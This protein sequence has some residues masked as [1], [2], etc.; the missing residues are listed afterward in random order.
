MMFALLHLPLCEERTG[1]S[2]ITESFIYGVSSPLS[3]LSWICLQISSCF[4]FQ[5]SI[6]SGCESSML[7]FASGQDEFG[8]AEH[9]CTILSV[10]LLPVTTRQSLY[11]GDDVGLPLPTPFVLSSKTWFKVPSLRFFLNCL[12]RSCFTFV[13]FLALSSPGL[14]LFCAYLSWL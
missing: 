3:L 14:F 10:L 4:F 13:C 8:A 12:P 5:A 6:S 2:L 7:S 11:S 9:N 1:P